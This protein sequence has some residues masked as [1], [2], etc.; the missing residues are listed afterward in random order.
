MTFNLQEET[1]TW[2]PGVTLGGH[3]DSVQD[4]AWEPKDGD[5]L[6]SVSVDQTTRLHAHWQAPTPS[7]V[8]AWADT[9]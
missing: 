1:E 5:F 8:R 7:E 2:Q 9:V 3:F 6:I 4:I